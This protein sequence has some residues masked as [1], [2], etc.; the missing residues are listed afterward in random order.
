VFPA[1]RLSVLATGN[2]LVE[3]GAK[4]GPGQIRNS[5]GPML[6]A[7]AARAEG[8]PWGTWSGSLD[9]FVWMCVGGYLVWGCRAPY[10]LLGIA[11]MPLAAALLALAWAAGGADAHPRE[12]GNV[13]LLLHVGLVLAAFA[14]FTL[15]A[16]LGALYLW[17][18]RR[19]KQRTPGILRVRAPALATL[20][21]L[22]ARSVAVGLPALTAGIGIGFARLE[23]TGGR[24]DATIVVTVLAWLVYASLLVLRWEAGWRGRRT[25]YVALAG[26]L[27]VLLVRVGLTPVTHF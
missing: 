21:M 23:E 25:A 3:A 18:E 11:V 2:E 13:F 15:A 26:F 5:N 12:F 20:D 17:Q 9:L 1:P 7:Q 16:G 22:G 19:L 14:G 4:P 24:L 8:F 27:L 6:V 10:R